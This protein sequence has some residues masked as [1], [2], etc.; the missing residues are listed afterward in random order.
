MLFELGTG[1]VIDR[2]IPGVSVRPFA[3]RLMHAYLLLRHFCDGPLKPFSI[4]IAVFISLLL[5]GNAPSQQRLIRVEKVQDGRLTFV[6]Y[7][8]KEYQQV[9]LSDLILSE[10][11]QRTGGSLPYPLNSTWDEP[12]DFKLLLLKGGLAQLRDTVTAKD[13]YRAAQE[14]AKKEGEGIWATPT[15]TPKPRTSQSP[16]PTPSSAPPV[17]APTKG[18]DVVDRISKKIADAGSFLWGWLVKLSP[19]GIGGLAVTG[20]IYFFW[21]RRR[22]RLLIMGQI[23]AGKTAIFSRLVDPTINSEKILKLQQTK[24]KQ[25]VRF[26]R[27]IQYAKFEIYPRL[28][29]VP[30]SAF[31]TAWD[32]LTRFRFIRRH[33]LIL[34]LAPTMKNLKTETGEV[35]DDKYLAI[36]LGYVQSFMEGALGARK[37]RKPKVVILYLNKFDLVSDFPPGD[38]LAM[39][40]EN[41]F[42]NVFKEHQQSVELATKKAH[43]K[44]HVVVG[45]A[46]R[47]WNCDNLIT[48]VGKSL[49]GN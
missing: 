8:L 33:A 5:A 42:L 11:L 3:I 21:I 1:V 41:E 7:N 23:S 24:A 29:D 36:Q 17:V 10:N 35:F 15:P 46:L 14:S 18:P 34:V 2:L 22:V 4:L 47:G 30:G 49:Y 31:S 38:S 28:T 44:L 12:P 26:R 20:L 9:D 16:S 45:S 40:H 25:K 13:I 48:L 43:I 19:I 6:E 32:E 27:H 39:K 37:T